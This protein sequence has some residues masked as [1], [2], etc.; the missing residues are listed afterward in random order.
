[1]VVAMHLGEY[2]NF[3]KMFK[4]IRKLIFTKYILVYLIAISSAILLIGDILNLTLFQFKLGLFGDIAFLIVT[5]IPFVILPIFAVSTL[6]V[7]KNKIDNLKIY[8]KLLYIAIVILASLSLL[9]ISDNF[10]YSNLNYGLWV[11]IGGICLGMNLLSYKI[12]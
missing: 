7:F 10:I 9:K 11:L 12:K 8:Y 1:M 3:Y 6:G 4:F 5:A 2:I